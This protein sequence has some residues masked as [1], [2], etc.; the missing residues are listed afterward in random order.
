MASSSIARECRGRAAWRQR[1]GSIVPPPPALA[2]PSF[3]AAPAGPRVRAA[4]PHR[5]PW[6]EAAAGSSSSAPSTGLVDPA[7]DRAGPPPQQTQPAQTSPSKPGQPSKEATTSPT[8]RKGQRSSAAPS[9]PTDSSPRGSPPA[10][11]TGKSAT[12]KKGG[13]GGGGT[14]KQGRK[15]EPPAPAAASGAAA[16]RPWWGSNPQLEKQIPQLLQ[17]NQPA[18]ARRLLELCAEREAP[19]TQFYLGVVVGQLEG[20]PAACPYYEAALKQL[21]LL[22]AAR[23]NLIRGLI[24]R[25]APADLRAAIELAELSAGL[26]PSVAEM[27]YQLGVVLMQQGMHERAAAAY[28]AT[29]RLAPAHRG[30]LINGVHTLGLL[31][32]DDAKARRRLEAVAKLGVAAGAWLHPMQRPPHLVPGLRSKPWHDA[33]DFRFCA[34]LERAYPAIRAEVL[35]MRRH[36]GSFTPV[37][38]RAAHDSSLVAAGEWRELPLFGNGAR[39]AENCAR[40]P[41]TAR[42]MEAVPEAVE[43]AMAGGG[44]TLFSVLQPGTHLRPHCGSSNTRLTCHLGIVCPKGVS[45]RAGDEWREWEEGRCLVFDDSWEHE[46]RHAGESERIVLLVNFWHPGLPPG[47]RQIK[48]DNG[49]YE[50]I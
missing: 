26:Q 3:A 19:I 1:P 30:A 7:R 6:P 11:R 49:G 20:E 17:S 43:L 50:A 12:P 22:H 31:P 21:P 47:E 32:P 28:E 37:G 39:H 24:K 35:E 4:R 13:K 8:H 38:G 25:G 46:V 15:P 23:N 41:V 33:R 29:L 44:E 9:A 2:F 16:S 10:P 18:E 27:Q 5:G 34:L 14:P 36:A 40:C 48:L 45:I 42:T